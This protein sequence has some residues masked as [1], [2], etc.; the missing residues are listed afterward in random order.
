MPVFVD[1]S[2]QIYSSLHVPHT[3]LYHWLTNAQCV[4]MA[5]FIAVA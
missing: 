1:T 5:N 4:L 3:P 2:E